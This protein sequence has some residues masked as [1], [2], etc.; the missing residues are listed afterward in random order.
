MNGVPPLK[1][2]IARPWWDALAHHGLVM[3]RCEDCAAWIFY[4]RAFCPSCGGRSLTWLPIDL[5]ATLYSF[6]IAHTPVSE[7]FAHLHS[8]VM[9]LVELSNGIRL[10]T[11]IECRDTAQLRIGMALHAVFDRPA[12]MADT[13]LSF[14]NAVDMTSSRT[15][16]ASY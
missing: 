11:T 7:R 8:P 4:P 6:A 15:V 9:A 5:R 14:A 2:A 1:T 12:G 10:P 16:S 13:M 3:Q